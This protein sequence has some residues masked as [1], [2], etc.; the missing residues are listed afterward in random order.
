SRWDA[1]A[2]RTEVKV[3]PWEEVCAMVGQGSALTAVGAMT[4]ATLF[5]GVNDPAKHGSFWAAFQVGTLSLTSGASEWEMI[6]RYMEEGPDALDEPAAIT[7]DGLIAEYCQTHRISREQFSGARRLWWELNGTRLGLLRIK[8]Q[9]KLEERYLRRFLANHPELAHW[10]DP[11]PPEQWAKPS[12]R[13]TLAN[14]LL[15][16]EYRK[17]SSIFNVGDVRTL[18][19]EPTDD[20]A[21]HP[22]YQAMG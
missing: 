10:S 8:I 17:G 12:G 16:N 19:G 7:F 18:L 2:K 9:T 13:L 4:Q 21:A 20:S 22:F 3:F 6:R 15:R 14:Y 1:E 5:M 11:L